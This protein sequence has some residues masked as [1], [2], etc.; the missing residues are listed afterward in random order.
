MSLAC[1]L[2]ATKALPDV[3]ELQTRYGQ[4]HPLSLHQLALAFKYTSNFFRLRKKIIN[5]IL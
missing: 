1:S 4:P 2:Q 5:N 3:A